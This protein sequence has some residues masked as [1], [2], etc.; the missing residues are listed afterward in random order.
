MAA[1]FSFFPPEICAALL[2]WSSSH[3]PFLLALWHQSFMTASF[4]AQAATTLNLEFKKIK[5]YVCKNKQCHLGVSTP[6]A[7]S[8]IGSKI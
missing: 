6:E 4:G 7:G 2:V 8:E 3:F 1:S 5:V